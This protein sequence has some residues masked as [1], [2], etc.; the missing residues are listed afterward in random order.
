MR[1]YN[2]QCQ[3]EYDAGLKIQRIQELGSQIP[4]GNVKLSEFVIIYPEGD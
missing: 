1:E 4:V 2:D 3:V